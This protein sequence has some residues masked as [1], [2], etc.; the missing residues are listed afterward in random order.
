[1]PPHDFAEPR[2]SAPALPPG[3][4]IYAVGDIHGCAD[5]LSEVILRIEEDRIRRPADRTLEIYLGDYIDR[6]SNSREVIEALAWRIVERHAVCLRGNHEALLE[7]S[8]EDPACLHSWLSIGGA[9]TLKSYGILAE[10]GSISEQELHRNLND[11]F[12]EAHRLFLKCL[13]NTFSCG[14]FLFVHAGIRPG[15]PLRQQS[16]RDLL[17]IRDD[18]LLSKQN[19]GPIVV[20][21]HTP[22]ARP[23]FLA[24]RINIDTGAFFSGVLTCIAIEGTEVMVI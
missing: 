19:H 1:M 8:L 24:N 5:L 9:N 2:F 14:D 10:T 12:P 21:G 22:V 4:R 15:I 6:G 7:A 13:R 20:H 23:D 11:A 3:L 17:W 16:L 18:F